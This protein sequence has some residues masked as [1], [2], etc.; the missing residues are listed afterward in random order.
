MPIYNLIEYSHNY[1][2]KSGSLRLY[3]RDELD[4]DNNGNTVDFTDNNIDDSFKYKEK[5]TS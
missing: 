5:M 1:S 3:Y 4:F 2:K